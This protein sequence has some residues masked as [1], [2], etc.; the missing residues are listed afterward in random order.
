MKKTGA[1]IVIRSLK[2]QG[3]DLIFGYPGGSIMRY[4]VLYSSGLQL[5]FSAMN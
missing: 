4:D 3:V 5:A 1:E 2:T